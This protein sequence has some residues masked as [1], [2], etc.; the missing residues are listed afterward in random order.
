MDTPAGPYFGK[1]YDWDQDHGALLVNPKGLTKTAL[2]LKPGDKPHTWTA[3]YGSL[4]F[5]QVARELPL[6]GINEA[7]LT[8]EIMVVGSQDPLPDQRFTVNELQWIQLQLDQYATVREV[9]ENVESIRISR[10][11]ARVHYLICEESG[12]CGVVEVLNGKF[13]HPWGEDLPVRALANH[14]YQDSLTYIKKF[15]GFGGDG[16][17][18]ATTYSLDRFARAASLAASFDPA[19]EI[20]ESKAF[21]I[22]EAVKQEHSQWNVVYHLKAR[23]VAYRNVG[24]S[25]IRRVSL[26]DLDFS[27]RKKIF[28]RD[29]RSDGKFIPFTS[30]MNRE[31]LE[32]TTSLHPLPGDALNQ[33][34]SYPDSDSVKCP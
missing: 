30:A 18:P 20:A 16:K 26:K 23:E 15:T 17:I 12:V 19:T 8:V 1:S 32:K 9:M 33:I 24:E 14:P 11:Q 3:T 13:V 29:F 2:A 31:L 25:A 21:S 5:N 22:L 28:G 34:L 4:T 6:A 10:I 27:C 7:G